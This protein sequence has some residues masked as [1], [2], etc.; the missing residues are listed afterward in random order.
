MAVDDA[1][2]MLV[3]IAAP[4]AR[5]RCEFSVRSDLMQITTEVDAALDPL[6]TRSFG[7]LVLTCLA[8][9]VTAVGLPTAAGQHGRVCISLTKN[10]ETSPG[11]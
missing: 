3:R 4:N 5:L 2:A 8:D 10:A 7:W 6:P 9:E 1:C 11:S